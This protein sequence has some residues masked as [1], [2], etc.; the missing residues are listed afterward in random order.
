MVTIS[1]TPSLKM[2][3]GGAWIGITYTSHAQGCDYPAIV[4]LVAHNTMSQTVYISTA[5]VLFPPGQSV[6]TYAFVF[7]FPSGTTL[8]STIFAVLSSSYAPFTMSTI[9]VFTTP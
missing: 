7:G 8:N 3:N 2:M 6:T 9:F 5:T 4:F 1:G